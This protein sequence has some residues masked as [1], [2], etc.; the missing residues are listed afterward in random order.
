MAHQEETTVEEQRVHFGVPERLL[1][2]FLLFLAAV[3]T[4]ITY[5]FLTAGAGR[6]LNP[7]MDW[8]FHTGGVIAFASVK[9]GLTAAC[10]IWIGRRAPPAMA[11]TA[12]LVALAIYVPITGVHIYNLWGHGL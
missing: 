8:I 5:L 9:V 10:L 3:D 11:R 1:L 2:L 6:E 4:W 12:S 7:L